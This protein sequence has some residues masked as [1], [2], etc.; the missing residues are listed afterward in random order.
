MR[1]D[2][3]LFYPILHTGSKLILKR[4]CFAKQITI[5]LI[6]PIDSMSL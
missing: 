1:E 5:H 6:K 2:L 3:A 4:M